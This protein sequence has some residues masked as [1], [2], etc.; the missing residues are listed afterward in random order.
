[1]SFVAF[2]NLTVGGVYQL[3]WSVAWYWSNQLVRFTVTNDV[4]TQMVGGVAGS[5]D[6][7]LAKPVLDGA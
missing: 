5:E 3:Q 7:R 4:Y 1:M 6:Y 2:S